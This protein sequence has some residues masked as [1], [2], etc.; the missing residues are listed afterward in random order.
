MANEYAIKLPYCA[1]FNKASQAVDACVGARRYATFNGV[2]YSE[3]ARTQ[4]N[5]ALSKPNSNASILS[6]QFSQ[7]KRSFTMTSSNEK[8]R[9]ALLGCGYWGKNLLRVLMELRGAHLALVADPS[10]AAQDYVRARYPDLRVSGDERDVFE[11]DAIDAV[12]IA[13]PAND[14]YRAASLAL[15][16]G[17]HAFVEKPLATSSV[18]AQELVEC[19]AK[20]GLALMAGHTFLFNSAVNYLKDMIDTSCGARFHSTLTS[21]RM[22]PRLRRRLYMYCTSPMLPES[23]ISFR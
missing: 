16:A 6:S 2:A 23:I 10:G 5:F 3:F 9:I 21:D 11:S 12:A 19:A 15:N 4:T 22:M 13:T 20:K 14:H 7:Q 18:A 1:K 17:K 8:V